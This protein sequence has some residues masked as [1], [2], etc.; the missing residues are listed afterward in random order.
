MVQIRAGDTAAMPPADPAEEIISRRLVAWLDEVLDGRAPNT[1]RFC[2]NCYHPLARERSE[3][4]HCGTSAAA[5]PAVAKVPIE[6][7]DAHRRRRGREG[8]VVRSIAWGGLTLGV[9][10][11]LL[12]L[13]FGG[14]HWWTASL[15][16]GL[17]VFFYIL[18]ANLANS[19]GDAWGYRWGLALFRKTWERHIAARNG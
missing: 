19:L 9:T 11:A 5:V 14:V 12:P 16:F 1:G 4:P 17:M 13:A 10:A 6:I 18:A 3:C 2:G 15:F 7:I 8:A